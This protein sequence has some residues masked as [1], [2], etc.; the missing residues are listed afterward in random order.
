MC[1][2]PPLETSLKAMQTVWA[3]LKYQPPSQNHSTGALLKVQSSGPRAGQSLARSL[4]QV[5][6]HAIKETPSFIE[7]MALRVPPPN[8]PSLQRIAIFYSLLVLLW[9]L[10]L[11]ST[12][13][14]ETRKGE[15]CPSFLFPTVLCCPRCSENSGGGSESTEPTGKNWI[16]SCS[17]ASH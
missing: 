3:F 9:A 14:L 17:S 5:S 6:S 16:P 10:C 4:V 1:T 12:L 2:A 7:E 11:T 15:F 8:S 13:L